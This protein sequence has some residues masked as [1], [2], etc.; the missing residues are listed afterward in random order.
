VA[1]SK[2]ESEADA[3][4]V[5]STPAN[6][7]LLRMEGIVKRFPGVLALDDVNFEVRA[8]E[9]HALMG[10]NGAGKS[11]LIKV[12]TG[13][14]PPDAGVMVLRGQRLR[15]RSPAEAE[16]FG[17]SAVYQEIN[18]IPE[19]SIAEN[20]CLGRQPRRF[21]LI[22]W[23]GVRRRGAAAMRRLGL[24]V[25]VRRRL[26]ACPVALQ[27]MTAIARALDVDAR[28]LVLDEPT[29]S[30]DEPERRELFR[31]MRRLREADIGI[32]FITHFIDEVYAVSDRIT[33]LR[34]GRRIT[35]AR[36]AD[37]PRLSLI[38][39]MLGKQT[40][41]GAAAGDGH[42]G[43]PSAES[44]RRTA[45]VLVE[46]RGLGRRGAVDHV[47]VR[48]GEGEVVGLAG[49]LGSGRTETARLLFG[50]DRVERGEVLFRGRPVRV[51][52]P[53]HAIRLGFGFCPEDRKADGLAL[54]LS[55]EE[56]LVLAL[57]ARRGLL[58]PLSRT[59]RREL[60]DRFVRMLDIRAASAAADVR[61]LSGGTQ[62]K[63]LVARWLAT[64]P[65][66]LILDEPTRGIDVGAKAEVERL[67]GDLRNRGM[68][69]LFI[70]SEL[71]E[72]VRTADRIVVLRDRRSI[73]ELTADEV[74][75]GRIMSMM[76]EGCEAA[77]TEH[78]DGK[79][80]CSC[81]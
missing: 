66:F 1:S 76:A 16:R 22:D 13:V 3:A 26:G 57:Q 19:L 10:E 80:Q 65:C 30:L 21:G 47:D 40:V 51:R 23:R 17:I 24:E 58:R 4:A 42:A 7:P 29:S 59:E 34:N 62:Q 43:R 25:D 6:A 41:Q 46:G 44:G 14:Y 18:L 63:V 8:G 71:E 52:T 15:P 49:L 11:T 56:N 78:A 31:V 77:N 75:L 72:V 53:R 2:I 55:L 35:T 70:S 68:G 33:V 32:V 69:V 38:S 81:S 79:E 5:G 48:V 73:G 60:V 36:T 12:L 61:T 54:N 74:D 50:A 20:I 67:V 27:Q 28:L 45:P 64:D 9:I 37:L 39:A